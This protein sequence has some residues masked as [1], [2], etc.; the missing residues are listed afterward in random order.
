[1]VPAAGV[2]LAGFF[3]PIA[4][5]S[6]GD[7][8]G[9]LADAIDPATGEYL[10]ISR[11]FDPTD[12]A[13]LS[14]L[15]IQRASGSA[16]SDVGQRYQDLRIL[17]DG[18]AQFISAETSRALKSLVDSKQIK[19][20]SVEPT[21]GTDWAEVKVAYQNIPRRERRDPRVALGRPI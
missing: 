16:V 5:V 1:M 6:P 20:D 11:G 17:D 7:P 2:T 21:I 9:I 12:A 19:L 8:P 13:V 10:S 3:V 15:T 18:A 4:Y 14:S